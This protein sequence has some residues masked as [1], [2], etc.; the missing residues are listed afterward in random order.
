MNKNILEI[1]A[2][3]YGPE[4]AGAVADRLEE[5]ANRRMGEILPPPA[6]PS[7]GLPLDETDSFL[8]T[9]G[10]Q[11]RGPDHPPLEYLNAF[12]GEFLSGRFSGVH[13]LPFFPYTSDD[14]FSISDYTR[15]VPE[16]GDW[17]HV[18]ALGHRFRLMS[19]L[20]LNHCSVSHSWFQAF[21]AG[22][23]PYTGYFIT[24]SPDED[25]SMIAR[26]RALPLLTPFETPRGVLHV[27]TTFSADQVDLNFASPDVLLEMLD[28]FLFHVSRGIGV[29]RLDAI[30]YLWKERGHRSLH[31]PKTHAVVRLFR[32]II[33]RYVPWVVLLT[34]TNVPHRENLSYLGTGSDEAH[35]VYQFALPPLTLDAFLRGD[36][37]H[38]RR[39][40]R[41]L[42]PPDGR[43]TYFNFLASHDGVGMLPS[44]GILSE[45]ERA[46]LIRSVEQRGGLVSYKATPDGPIP[47]ELNVN[48]F[49]A[50]A[51][52]SLPEDL[53]IRKFLAS[54]GI[55]LSLPGV[56]G[57]YVHSFLGSENWTEGVAQ[58][59]MNRTI[60]RRKFDYPVLAEELRDPGSLRGRI[61]RGY[62]RMLEVRRSC[63]A[64]HPAGGLEVLESPDEIL[65]FIR[66]AP[67]GGER[68]LCAVNVSSRKISWE[69][70]P[71]LPSRAAD[72]ISRRPVTD[73][74]SPLLLEP[75]EVLW[76]PL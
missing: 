21:L 63:R 35:M 13:I 70:C 25:L 49:S 16:W 58:T 11:F 18:A 53:R 64:F 33:D 2:F 42:P 57:I 60:N 24:A 48:Y 7:G 32:A 4:Q 59:G 36:A 43:T 1:L 62:S 19:D 50:V 40:A 6:V 29:I 10:D 17:E 66:T 23:E 51:E 38:L 54:Q 75:W 74:G 31:H 8:I 22:R 65:A 69:A 44:H 71:V 12:A 3:L 5:M 15:V 47:Y 28:I 46:G 30:A 27:W 20:V 26:P 52:A 39:W 68:I 56:P 76:I 73:P 41:E 34:E 67:E 72:L 37:G 55:I 9:Y 14:G 45:E 61:L